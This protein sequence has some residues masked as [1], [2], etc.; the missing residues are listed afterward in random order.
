MKRIGYPNPT[1][2]SIMDENNTKKLMEI[3][4]NLG[5]PAMIIN[6]GTGHDSMIMTDFTD[7]NMIYLPSHKGVSHHK[8]EYT[9]LDDIEKGTN[10]LSEFIKYLSK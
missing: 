2:P 9:S 8:D 3:S 5:Y 6:K 1:P 4:K 10:V 7:T